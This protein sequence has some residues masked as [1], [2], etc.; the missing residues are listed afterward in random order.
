[1]ETLLDA[2]V[3]LFDLI[4]TPFDAL[5]ELENT[6]WFLANGVSWLCIIIL[7]VAVAYWLKK[8]KVFDA[9]EDKSQTAH[10]FLGKNHK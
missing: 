7:I 4:L 8:L 5:R 3:S 6:N 2:I 10:S 9:D 1:M